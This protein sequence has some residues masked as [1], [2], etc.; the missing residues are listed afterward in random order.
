MLTS[1]RTAILLMSGLLLGTAGARVW[2]AESKAAA[3][4]S[5]AAAAEDPGDKS[6]LGILT[7]LLTDPATHEAQK[8]CTPDQLYSRHDVVGDPEA[9]FR[10]H[11]D[12]RS[13]APYGGRVHLPSRYTGPVA[14][15]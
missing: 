11:F 3:P 13:S 10:G 7:P 6:L 14:A 8:N 9:C 12:M 5:V 4:V 1:K 15:I 2:A